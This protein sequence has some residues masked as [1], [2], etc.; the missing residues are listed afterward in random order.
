MIEN[1]NKH[2][3]FTI[4]QSSRFGKVN[5]K[6]AP[7]CKAA[8]AATYPPFFKSSLT[9]ASSYAPSLIAKNNF[10]SFVSNLTVTVSPGPNPFPKS[11]PSLFD[12]FL[13]FPGLNNAN[14]NFESEKALNLIF[15]VI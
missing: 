8:T 9:K 14:P 2:K 5:E 1:A 12:P 7:S 10:P 15:P 3:T 4:D 13:I 11:M 6:L